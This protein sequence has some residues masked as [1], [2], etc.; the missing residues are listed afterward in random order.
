MS[1]LII[2]PKKTITWQCSFRKIPLFGFHNWIISDLDRSWAVHCSSMTFEECPMHLTTPKQCIWLRDCMPYNIQ[3]PC[4]VLCFRIF[5]SP[6]NFVWVQ[7]L[8]GGCGT[9]KFVLK[10]TKENV[11]GQNY[12]SPTKLSSNKNVFR[13][14]RMSSGQK[15]PE[16]M[17]YLVN[18]CCL[19]I[20]NTVN[21][22]YLGGSWSHARD[23]FFRQKNEQP[24]KWRQMG[25]C[26]EAKRR[27]FQGYS[28]YCTYWCVKVQ[29]STSTVPGS[30]YSVAGSCTW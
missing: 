23:I 10:S 14:K 15:C 2:S 21:H 5:L 6:D 1:I 17:Q 29:H 9:R 8:P 24:T 13:R 3:F 12:Y 20:N 26:L 22:R 30:P 11:L 27:S 25:F 4:S 16:T 19:I 18:T 7:F 28:S